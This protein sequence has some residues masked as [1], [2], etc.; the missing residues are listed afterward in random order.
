MLLGATLD[1]FSLHMF[2]E[3]LHVRWC[4]T[5]LNFANNFCG[6]CMFLWT[7]Q[8]DSIGFGSFGSF[9]SF[10][11]HL[12]EAPVYASIRRSDQYKTIG[13][14]TVVWNV[15]QQ[16]NAYKRRCSL[17]VDPEYFSQGF[18]D[19]EK[20]LGRGRGSLVMLCYTFLRAK[21]PKTLQFL[22]SS[23]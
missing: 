18:I 1:I 15:L 6:F 9:G 17:P 5:F 20:L 12:E 23:V 3:R 7:T 16:R 10:P 14:E 19:D 4:F 21:W 22:P 2:L 8:I 11:G 13:S